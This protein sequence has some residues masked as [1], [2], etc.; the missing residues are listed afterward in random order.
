LFELVDNKSKKMG[1]ETETKANNHE[2]SKEKQ[3]QYDG[4]TWADFIW[5]GETGQFFGRTGASWGKDERNIILF[6]MRVHI[7]FP[8]VVLI[9]NTPGNRL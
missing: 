6:T 1:T 7:S 2:L 9:D 5:N 8:P 3:A 4:G